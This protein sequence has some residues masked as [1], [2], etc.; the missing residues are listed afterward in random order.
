MTVPVNLPSNKLEGVYGV[1]NEPGES[2]NCA[3]TITIEK[4]GE[5]YT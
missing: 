4:A 1:S 2:E 3:I 5:G